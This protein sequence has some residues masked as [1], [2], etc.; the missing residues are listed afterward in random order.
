[1][2][3]G[4][5]LSRIAGLIRTSVFAHYLGASLHASAFTAA[6]RMPNV[7]QNLLGEGTLSA[8][9]IP[10]YAGLLE[11]G[12]REAAGRLAGAVFALLLAL[13][14][15]LALIGSLAAPLIVH[16]FV[17][18]FSTEAK[19]VTVACLRV[20]FPMTGVLVLSAW[21]LGILNSHRSFFLPYVAPVLWNAAMIGALVAFGARL[22]G[23]SLVIALAWAALIGGALQFLVQLPRVFRLEP[24]W[25]IRWDLRSPPVR[26]VVRNAGPAIL[27]RGAVQL[28]GWADLFLASFLF[29]G[30]V[31]VLGYAQTLYLL[32][33]SLFGMSIA[34]AELPEMSRAGQDRL[35]AIRARLDNGLRN[36]AALVV[37]S[38]VAYLLLGDII[39][40]A[41]FGRGRFMPADTLIVSLT[42][43]A[44]ALGLI[45]STATRLH[46]SALYAMQD[47][48]T[49]ARIA[50]IR[51]TISAMIGAGLMLILERYAAGVGPISIVPAAGVSRDAAFRPLGAVGLALGAAVGAWI[52]FSLLRRATAGRI[53]ASVGASPRWARL[54]AAAIV[55]ALAARL[56]QLALPPLPSIPM[57]ALVLALY[58][59]GYLALTRLLGIPEAWNALGGIGRRLQPRPRRGA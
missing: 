3:A 47:T 24:G 29:E 5:L 12:E 58:G 21:A 39:V 53:G 36:V 10:V 2:A 59:G 31:A 46:S 55:P 9:F 13:A 41:L 48:R 11:R 54:L 28:S 26:T 52:E 14:G 37:P 56:L 4:I 44:Y 18:D 19:E 42:L 7:L 50:F 22:D 23:R 38:A 40:S 32:P 8:S 43:G 30:A 1:V 17:P 57:A 35:H 20:I 51:V 27:G 49:P 25:R 6:L 33:V 34:V 16:I 45:A 15:G